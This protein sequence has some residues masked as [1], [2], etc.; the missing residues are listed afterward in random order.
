MEICCELT[1]RSAKTLR[2]CFIVNLVIV[3]DSP[4]DPS[5]FNIEFELV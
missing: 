4:K 1:E 5:W 2:S 3:Q